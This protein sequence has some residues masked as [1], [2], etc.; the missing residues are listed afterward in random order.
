MGKRY[1]H[2]EPHRIIGF[3]ESMQ[4]FQ[5]RGISCAT[6]RACCQ[7]GL[8]LAIQ[9]LPISSSPTM[10]TLP[11]KYLYRTKVRRLTGTII[12]STFVFLLPADNAPVEFNRFDQ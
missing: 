10:R 4:R 8:L 6:I 1:S 11:V 5:P 9:V 12:A 7:H 3:L 2:C